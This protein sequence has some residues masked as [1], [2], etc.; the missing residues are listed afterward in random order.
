MTSMAFPVSVPGASTSTIILQFQSATNANLAQTLA[1]N[2]WAALAGGSLNV[3]NL[4]TT[5]AIATKLNEFTIGDEGG[6]QNAGANNGTVPA[7]YL[8]IIDAF[9]AAHPA[10][11]TGANQTGET[12]L[13]QGGLTF[14][15]NGGSG[16]YLTS[17]GGNVFAGTGTGGDW[18]VL[19]D[20]GNNTVF[21]N[22][23]NLNIADNGAL[24]ST[25]GAGNNQIWLGSG[26]DTV[27]SFGSD[28]VFGGSGNATIFAASAGGTPD[29][30]F[31]GSGHLLFV[32][33][34]GNNTVVA[35][36]AATVFGGSGSGLYVEG[37]GS[38]LLDAQNG[39]DTV[40]GATAL[41]TTGTSDLFAQNGG[42]ITFFGDTR[43]LLIAG[44][45]NVTLNAGGSTGDNAFF[46]N[47]GADSLVG[48]AGTNFFVA[49]FNGG[50][51]MSGGANVNT[52]AFVNGAAGGNDL[53]QNWNAND[54][55]LLAGYAPGGITKQK[56]T[57]GSNH[58]TLSD[59][60]QI[61]VENFAH[62]ISASHITVT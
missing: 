26:A 23:A 56:V 42:S 61:T 4:P 28:T 30:V 31:G 1:N 27:T 43:N 5:P 60:T 35:G 47:S 33:S 25:V 57:G 15:T 34:T 32:A 6:V 18:T 11:V 12:V 20:G 8:G 13:G 10:T 55:L 53:I 22:S 24:P 44:P 40:F 52:F 3:K 29:V 14:N 2:F 36:G 46:G 39:A 45:G 59:G 7:G 16:F 50:S 62:K 54:Q 49:G 51:T 9:D 21:G 17:G 19:F 48:G 37:S 38:F 58:I 41:G